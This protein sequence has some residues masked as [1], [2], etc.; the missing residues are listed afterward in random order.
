MVHESHRVLVANGAA[1]RLSDEALKVVAR[2]RHATKLLVD[3]RRTIDD[4]LRDWNGRIIL[5]TR[6]H[7]TDLP[8]FAWSRFLVTDLGISSVGGSP[9]FNTHACAVALGFDVPELFGGAANSPMGVVTE[10]YGGYFAQLGA[11]SGSATPV[12]VEP[13]AAESEI[14]D[15]HVKS[16]KFYS[17]LYEGVA[18]EMVCAV[19]FAIEC[20]AHFVAEALLRH[21][22]QPLS[23][24]IL[25]I[26]AMFVEHAQ[27]SLEALD[28]DWRWGVPPPNLRDLMQPVRC[29]SLLS[30]T[31]YRQLRNAFVHYAPD[32]R[33]NVDA[34]VREVVDSD[35]EGLVSWMIETAIPEVDETAVVVAV[36]EATRALA[37]G[38]TE[39]RVRRV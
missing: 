32:T 31:G 39:W 9:I 17:G 18:S 28:R 30:S 5:P 24:S 23:Y 33:W 15:R 29:S 21:S 1:L 8:R 13:F 3:R 19:L 22:P 37:Q 4:I 14:R 2:S 34:K 25:K 27:A 12:F 7:F 16:L 10:E 11:M 6:K 26:S 35:G 38:L 20:G 36:T